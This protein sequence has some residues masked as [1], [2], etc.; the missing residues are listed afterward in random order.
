[1]TSYQGYTSHP[2]MWYIKWK[3][4]TSVI[5]C[6]LLH[7]D[8]SIR[9]ITIVNLVVFAK[10]GYFPI[11]YFQLNTAIFHEIVVVDEK[12]FHQVKGQCIA[13]IFYAACLEHLWTLKAQNEGVQMATYMG[14]FSNFS[15]VQSTLNKGYSWNSVCS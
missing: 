5:R 12:F 3:V 7:V 13:D 11:M 2:V 10:Y 6:I 1:M 9:S 4:L 15:S 8:I 14:K